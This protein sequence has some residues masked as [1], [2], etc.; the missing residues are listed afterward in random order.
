MDISQIRRENLNKVIGRRG[1]HGRIADF[2]REHDMS[3]TY[4]AQILNGHRNLGEKSA[5]NMEKK[6]GLAHGTLD[7]V[8]IGAGEKIAEPHSEYI[9][10]QLRPDQ[11]AILEGYEQSSDEVKKLILRLFGIPEDSEAK[12]KR[13]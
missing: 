13:K 10:N 2:A 4:L 1:K 3:E 9:K 12:D 11:I 7:A 8:W 6:V 5:R